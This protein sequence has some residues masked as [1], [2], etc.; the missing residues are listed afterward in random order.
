MT[1]LILSSGAAWGGPQPHC[2][3][4]SLLPHLLAFFSSSATSWFLKTRKTPSTSWEAG[5]SG[6]PAIFGS[7]P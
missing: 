4:G 6:P 1:F 2:K 5:V 3:Q 7:W